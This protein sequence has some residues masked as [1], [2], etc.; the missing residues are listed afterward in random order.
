MQIKKKRKIKYSGLVNDLTVENSHTYNVE[1]LA[2]HNS[3]A[4]CLISYLIR[5]TKIDPIEY[6]L[7]FQRFYNSGR[8][9]PDNVSFQEFTFEDFMHRETME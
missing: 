1:G 7:L 4:G 6:D 9:T 3:A 5:I 2:V 8:N